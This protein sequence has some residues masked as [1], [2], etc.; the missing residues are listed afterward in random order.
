M[1]L[2]TAPEQPNV[3][4]PAPTTHAATRVRRRTL[5]DRREAYAPLVLDD[6]LA[7][8][9]EPVRLSIVVVTHQSVDQIADC[10]SSLKRVSH[11]VCGEIIVVDNASTDGTIELVRRCHPEVR[12]IGKRLRHGFSVNCNIGA[13]AASGDYILLLNP[14]TVVRPHALDRLVQYLDDHIEVAAVG[15]RLV[16][17]DGSHQASARRFPEVRSALV[18][19]TPLRLLA[20]SGASERRH[21]MLDEDWAGVVCDVDWLLGAALMIRAQLY[22]EV[23]GLDD[24]Y[25]LYCEDIDLCWR[26]HEQGW[27]IR[28]LP[29]AVVQH[30]LG[31]HTR[32]RF[33]TPLTLWHLRS[34]VRF[35]RRHGLGRPSPRCVGPVH[36]R[37]TTAESSEDAPL[38]TNP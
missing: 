32:K 35:V 37:T 27:A 6:D 36:L 15:P 26:L 21:L 17:P 2:P 9:S 29:S 5:A 28:Y 12:L 14:D 18:R 16:Y 23:G 1:A 33:L 24:G 22:D 34:M 20:Q 30:D 25:R 13:V 7:P 31:E 10:L 4:G 8:S 3:D 11:E 19:R 38:R